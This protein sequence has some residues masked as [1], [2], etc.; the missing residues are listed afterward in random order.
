[1]RSRFLFLGLVF[2]LAAIG[3]KKGS[4]IVGTWHTQ[5]TVINLPAYVDETFN[6]DGTFTSQTKLARTDG[7]VSINGTDKGTWTLVKD[8]LT[9][10]VDDID[11]KFSGVNARGVE[12]AQKMFD[13]RKPQIL[14]LTNEH[15]THT[16]KWEGDDKFTIVTSKGETQIYR[17]TK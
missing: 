16:L 13:Q 6:S 7:K 5:S 4:P 3:C 14:K 11:W 15:P 2:V 10:K 9:E 1:M 8:Q 17:R 12:R